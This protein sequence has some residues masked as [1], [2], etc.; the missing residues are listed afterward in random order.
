MKYYTLELL[1]LCQ[2]LDNTEAYNEWERRSRQYGDEF[3]KC[4]K[5]LPENL[6]RVLDE[7]FFHD[8]QILSFQL[9]KVDDKSMDAMLQLS[10]YNVKGTLIHQEVEAL[11]MDFR[12]DNMP[13]SEYLYGEIL[14]DEQGFWTH[15]FIF[16]DSNEIHIQ[17]KQLKWVSE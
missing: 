12:R 7:S 14:W 17:C 2:K 6:L 11:N 5:R 9:N 16:T 13:I 10:G 1:G 15:D 4:R 8:S 3:Q